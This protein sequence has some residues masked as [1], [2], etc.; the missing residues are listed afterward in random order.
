MVW[1]KYIPGG[2]CLFQLDN[3][4]WNGAVFIPKN[5]LSL[6]EIPEK[7]VQAAL[8]RKCGCCGNERKCFE[9]ATDKEIEVYKALS[10]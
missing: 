5:G 3:V 4:D 8:S 10:N 2:Q 6:A 9:I 7:Y 1:L